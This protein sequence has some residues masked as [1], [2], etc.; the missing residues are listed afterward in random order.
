MLSSDIMDNPRLLCLQERSQDS[1][2]IALM[3]RK[4]QTFYN[5]VDTELNATVMKETDVKTKALQGEANIERKRGNPNPI[6][7]T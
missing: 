6:S 5:S 3:V 1:R 2:V 4:V 7:G